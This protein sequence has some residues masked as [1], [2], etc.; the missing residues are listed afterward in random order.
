MRRTV[1][2]RN[3]TKAFWASKLFSNRNATVVIIQNVILGQLGTFVT[4]QPCKQTQTKIVFPASE[5]RTI[6]P[7]ILQP[8]QLS[9]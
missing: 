8:Q 5:F 1:V 6:D 2:N 7:F 3:S 4:I 9:L